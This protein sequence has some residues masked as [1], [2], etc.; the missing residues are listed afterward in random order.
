[1]PAIDRGNGAEQ[2][3]GDLVLV[4]LI[5]L[6]CDALISRE[7]AYAAVEGDAGQLYEVTKVRVSVLKAF[8]C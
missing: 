1:M 8:L 3:K 7:A 6:M 5:A 2:F 4:R